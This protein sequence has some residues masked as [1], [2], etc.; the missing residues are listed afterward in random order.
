MIRLFTALELPEDVR[1][2]LAGL[3]GGVPGARW[4]P[5]E[6]MHLTLRFIGN[7]DE[8]MFEDVGAGLMQVYAPGFDL[9]LEGI[10]N[11]ARGRAPTAL[12]VGVARNPALHRL[13]ERIEAALTGAG[14]APEGRKFVPHVALA[15][16]R[17][18]PRGR[19]EGFIAAH[20]LVRLPAFPVK[21]FVLFSSFL[22]RAG[23]SYRVE[24]AYPLD[25]S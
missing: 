6:S 2:Y 5:A 19:V 13:Q 14:L 12:W 3:A 11:F 15:R 25:V 18:S 8:T 24:A 17:N 23:A 1:T 4:I 20:N 16:L 22:G 10:G 7:V 9:V 21:R